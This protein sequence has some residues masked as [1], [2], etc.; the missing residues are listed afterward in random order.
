MRTDVCIKCDNP[1]EANRTWDA[2]CHSC[3]RDYQRAWE[4]AN[5]KS[6]WAKK[7]KYRNELRPGYVNWQSMKDRCQNPKSI[8]YP[9]YGAKGVTVCDRWNHKEMGLTNFLADM[10]PKPSTEHSIDRINPF[11]NYTPENCRWATEAEQQQNRRE[12]YKVGA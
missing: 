10:G 12:N 9:Y 8:S 3:R 2:W 7:K 4:R 5:A 6:Q 11:G 1:K